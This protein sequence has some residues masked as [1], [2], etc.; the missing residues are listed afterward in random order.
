MEKN[1]AIEGGKA[2]MK[3]A[4][5]VI[6][7]LACVGSLVYFATWWQQRCIDRWKE[8]AEKNRA[9]FIL[10]NQ[11]ANIRQDGRS[12]EEYFLKN[13]YYRIAVYGMGVLGQRLIKELN[14]SRIQ[15][16]YGIDKNRDMVYTDLKVV[17][18]EDELKKVDAVVVT[19]VKEFDA[20]QEKLLKKMQ[21]QVIAIEDILG[22]F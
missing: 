16:A 8:Q 10:M 5:K 12:L 18:M 19:V 17:T 2:I 15:I 21:C 3:R 11:W 1:I 14:N 6:G 4:I 22:E 20:I 9:M 13:G 7:G